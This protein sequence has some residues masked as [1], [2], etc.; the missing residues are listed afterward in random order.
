MCI[1]HKGKKNRGQSGLNFK[2]QAF[3]SYRLFVQSKYMSILTSPIATS[4]IS[5]YTVRSF[6]S[7]PGFNERKMVMHGS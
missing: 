1:I 7:T 2:K 4:L 3:D 5:A 6:E